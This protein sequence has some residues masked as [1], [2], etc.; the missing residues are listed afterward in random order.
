MHWSV[1]PRTLTCS[2]SS[3]TAVILPMA[4]SLLTAG[5]KCSVADCQSHVLVYC[6]R[7]LGPM[8]AVS[9]SP[10]HSCIRHTCHSYVGVRD[11]HFNER[12]CKYTTVWKTVQGLRLILI[13][14]KLTFGLWCS[15]IRCCSH[16]LKF[17]RSIKLYASA[18]NVMVSQLFV[19]KRV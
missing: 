5:I 3:L 17:E 9:N 10:Y 19:C 15:D 13:K 11:Q 6:S 12:L 16:L 1:R 14:T 4:F 18:Y 2:Y 8:D 7:R